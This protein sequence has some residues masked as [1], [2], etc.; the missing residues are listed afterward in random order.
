[1]DRIHTVGGRSFVRVA[2]EIKRAQKWVTPYKSSNDGFAQRLSGTRAARPAAAAASCQ[3]HNWWLPARQLV[4]SLV[5]LASCLS[6]RGWVRQVDGI[7][8]SADRVLLHICGLK[9][10]SISTCQSAGSDG[11]RLHVTLGPHN[12]SRYSAWLMYTVPTASWGCRNKKAEK[13]K[14]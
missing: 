14:S 10:P 11:R 7:P 5:E 1:M 3:I 9:S 12:C 2:S 13:L 8:P 6:V 4:R